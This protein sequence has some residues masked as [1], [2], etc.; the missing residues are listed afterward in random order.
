METGAI[1][2]TRTIS[3]SGTEVEEENM[4]RVKFIVWLIIVVII[5]GVLAV[6][7]YV[8]S[9]GQWQEG[10]RERVSQGI[11]ELLQENPYDQTAV[12][13]IVIDGL[14]WEEG[15]GSEGEFFPHIWNNLRPQGTLLTN[16]YIASPTVTTSSHTAMMS[17]RVSTV[18]NDG[19]IRPVFPTF[20]EYFR[21]ARTDYLTSAIEK[22]TRI[23]SGI[24]RPDANSLTEVNSL[25]SDAMD[26]EPDKTAL[27]LGKDL[28]YSLDQSS[29]GRYPLDDVL[30]VDSMRDIEVTEYF[31]A[32][33]P[34]VR[35]NIVV[36]N[37]GDVDE[38]G[39][40]A[41][42]PYYVDAIRWAD[43]YVYEMWEALQAET[44]YRDKSYFI[45]TTDHGRH[46]P[47][48]GGYPHHGCFCEG[49]RHSFMLLIGP[50]I[51]EG[52]VSDEPHT[53]CDLAPTVGRAMG[54]ATPGCSGEPMEE[55]FEDP[56][57]LP[58]Q[59]M[60]ETMEAVERDRIIV[61][62][63]DTAKLLLVNA[64]NE[65]ANR[66]IDENEE[67]L[68]MLY[69]A[70][71]ARFEA[72]IEEK[73]FWSW[74]L[75]GVYFTGPPQIDSIEDTRL[76]YPVYITDRAYA[77]VVVVGSFDD[78]EHVSWDILN[79][80]IEKGFIDLD[81]GTVTADADIS[82]IALLAPL[83]AA[84]GASWEDSHAT[85]AAYNI[86]LNTLARYEGREK[87]FD[88]GLENFIDDYLYRQPPNEIFTEGEISMRDR[89]W[90]IWSI[91]RVLFEAR[92]EHAPDLDPLLRRQYRLLVAFMHEWQDANAMLGGTGAFDDEIDM[93]A[94]GLGLS[95]MAEFKPWRKWELDELGYTMDIY[96][97]P[98]FAW[99]PHHFF[100]ILGQANALA[101]GWAA[102]DRLE[103][104]VND[105]GS[106]RHD[107]VDAQPSMAVDSDDWLENA[108]MLS[109]GLSR[110]E[111]ADYELYDLE[112]YPVVHQQEN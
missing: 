80:A 76:A 2:R 108:L 96:R 7:S 4:R 86:L 27:Y 68:P 34:D 44:R 26:F 88:D 30:L 54:F 9:N 69:L 45:I 60:T 98:L 64:M 19:H 103:L 41:E 83:V 46:I 12:F 43:R 104:F 57:S 1:I 33:I 35:P 109:Y 97:T 13:V 47:D 25:V 11:V 50:G 73:E 72:H 74:Q 112:M 106:I 87:V 18:P 36:V 29:C 14:R 8:R 99:P 65:F 48:R 28:I 102:R 77:R 38:C 23:P 49:C 10:Y 79:A 85:R 3:F 52:Y 20:I 62:D 107:L 37:L 5:A 53:E 61:D 90:L 94:Q 16:Y 89:L 39:H 75:P 82:T 56:S 93:V 31:R 92:S 71:A 101:G 17:G 58:E 15:V 6:T 42:W 24:F 70:T 51:R 32:K 81:E 55:I 110:F 21:D 78:A 91:E 22:L 84:Y 63:R 100:Y 95:A 111:F 59:R 67:L 105:D 66:Q 40:E